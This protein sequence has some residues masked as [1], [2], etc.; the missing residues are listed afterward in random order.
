VQSNGSF[1][2]EARRRGAETFVLKADLPRAPLAALFAA[3]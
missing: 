3:E 1:S 2:G